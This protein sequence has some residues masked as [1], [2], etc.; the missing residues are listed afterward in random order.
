MTTDVIPAAVDV[1]DLRC[2]IQD[3]YTEVAKTPEKGFH[4]HTGRPLALMLGYPGALISRLPASAVESFA[5]TGNPF[6]IGPLRSGETVLDI[7]CGAGF[8]SVIAAMRVGPAGRVIAVDMTM[9]MLEKASA[10]AKQAGVSNMEFREGLAESL[11]VEDSS[12]DVVISNGVINLCPD[13]MAV[14]AEVHRVL[15]PGGRI[16]IGD[17]VVHKEV[18]QSAKDNIDLWSD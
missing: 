11:P 12:V 10:S 5:G 15:K 9:A 14:M 13:K 8:D 6:S 3:K 16:Q 18:P 1:E 4:F 2:Q 17:I 7:G